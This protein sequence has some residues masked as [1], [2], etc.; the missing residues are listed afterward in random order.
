MR[1]LIGVAAFALAALV[2]A[3][4]ELALPV[5]GTALSVQLLPVTDAGR[6]RVW[7]GRT[8]VP[9]ELLD[10]FV[11]EQ[12]DAAQPAGADAVARPSKPY[13]SMDRGFGHAGF[14][15]I[16]VNIDT[17]QQFCAWL[18]KRTGRTIRLP[19]VSELQSI[20]PDDKPG[21]PPLDQ[22]AWHAGNSG[23][24][25]HRV[26]SSKPDARGF[27]D[28]Q[29]N[30][31]EWA[32]DAAGKPVVWG[33][34]FMDSPKDQGAGRVQPPSADWN[35]SDPQM[36]PSRWWLADGSFIGFRVACESLPGDN[37]PAPDAKPAPAAT[38]E[39]TP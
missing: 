14:P 6:V 16:S 7:M 36:P 18:S 15:A 33:G 30:V 35:A 31:A 17:A 22:R 13:I 23:G 24:T 32:L 11:Y 12:A 34:S 27:S 37:A 1:A 29:G 25:T 2:N 9:W 3:P 38:K 4:S 39:P 21:Q 26:G 8:E 10:A 5:R 19:R 28:L 20:C